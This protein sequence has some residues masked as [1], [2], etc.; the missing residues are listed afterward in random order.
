MQIIDENKFRKLLYHEDTAILED[1]WLPE[2]EQ[3]DV[4]TFKEQ[5]HINLDAR[6][7]YQPQ[8]FLSD[9]RNYHFAISPDLQLWLAK[10]VIKVNEITALQKTALIVTQDFITQLS[11]EQAIDEIQENRKRSTP[12]YFVE[13]E[14]AIEWLLKA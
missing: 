5:A 6:L 13:R 8:Y 10:E 1:V 7:K 9:L 4:D 3:M 14:E 2:S 11:I 12:A